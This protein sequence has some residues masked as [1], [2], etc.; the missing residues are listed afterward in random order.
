MSFGIAPASQLSH[1]ELAALFTASFEGYVVPMQIDEAA[2]RQMAEL[3]D[4]DLESSRIA[5]RDGE[6]VGL[7]NLGVRGKTGWIGGMGVVPDVRRE[8]VGQLL[9]RSVHGVARRLGIKAI[10]LEVIDSNTPAFE[11]YSKL[12][13]KTVR[14]LEIWS[15]DVKPPRSPVR[16]V[17]AA[18]AHEQVRELRRVREPWQRADVTLERLLVGENESRGLVADG[19]AAVVRL[20]PA[21]AVV[22]QIVAGDATT[23]EHLLAAALRLGRP[24][25]LSNLPARSIVGD[26][27]KELGGKV[28]LRQHEMRLEL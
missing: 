7:V 16:E 19:G 15:L 3:Y 13:Y 14:D 27:F 2:Y 11:L 28:E 25:R 20:T 21:A 23:A 18:E 6:P 5:L 12:G 22:E 9:M 8:G 24:V 10:R 26:A 1:A 4:F 17:P